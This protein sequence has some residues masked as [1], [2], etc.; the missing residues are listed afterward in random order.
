MRLL[1][2]T[3][4][5]T[6]RAVVLAWTLVVLLALLLA[7]WL[8]VTVVRQSN[9][10]R[11]AETTN[12]AQDK[13][14]AEANRRLTNAGQPPVPTP[15][16]GPAGL[17]G[18]PGPQGPPPTNTQVLQAVVNYCASGACTRQPTARQVAAAVAAYCEARSDCRGRPGAHGDTGTAGQPGSKGAQGAPG[19]GP[20]ADQIVAAV[21]DYCA[22][23]DNCRGPAGPAGPAGA[24]GKNGT[25]GKDGADPWPFTFT[26]TV[27]DN[28]VHS[29]TYTVTCTADGCNTATS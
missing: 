16:P 3:P 2:A 27:Q 1:P 23:R 18:Q 5:A 14:L 22:T 25:D 26:F 28:P 20:T 6:R 17:P 15:S 7:G 10:I 12:A 11:D 8:V 13:A 29:T 4:R 9:A 21:N 19:P 24:D